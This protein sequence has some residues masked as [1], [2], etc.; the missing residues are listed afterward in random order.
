MIKSLLTAWLVIHTL[1]A[2]VCQDSL[3]LRPKSRFVLGLSS[4]ELLHIGYGIDVSRKYHIG[5]TAGIGPSWGTA[6]PQFS[7]EQRILFATSDSPGQKGQWFFRQGFNYFP[8]G[9]DLLV[10]FSIGRDSKWDSNQDC[11]TFDLGFSTFIFY[12]R[13][14]EYSE[15]YYN[16]VPVIRVQRAFGIRRK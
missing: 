7:I 15:P 16:F 11:W 9:E 1:Q 8:F 10:T 4:P 2:A 6:W 14:Y 13:Q 5:I 3:V 12:N